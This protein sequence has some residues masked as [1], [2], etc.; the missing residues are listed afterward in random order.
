MIDI[1]VIR[2]DCEQRK[3][4]LAILRF[5]RNKKSEQFADWLRKYT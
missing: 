2:E 5:A 1:N 3:A 4:T